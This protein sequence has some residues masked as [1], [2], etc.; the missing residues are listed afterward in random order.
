MARISVGRAL[1]S[2]L[3]AMSAVAVATGPAIAQ[4]V[5]PAEPGKAPVTRLLARAAGPAEPVA[6]IFSD[7]GRI[8]LST[9]AVGTNNAA[10]ADLEVE[11]PPGG[12]VRRAFV[13]AAST[14]FTGYEPQDGD[15]T[16]DG[17]P[18]TWTGSR[19][20]TNGISSVNV[21]SDVTSLVKP[22]LDAASP[23]RIA[24]R[25]AEGAA[26]TLIDGVILAVVFDD[27][28][29][30]RDRAVVLAYGA[31]QVT[32]DRIRLVRLPDVP[33]SDVKATLGV[34]ISFGFQPT[35][36]DSTIDVN[37]V[38][39]TSSAGGQDDGVGR[40]GALITVGGLN[41]LASNPADPF[42][43]GNQSSC[44]RCDDELYDLT[45]FV[46]A[47]DVSL[48]ELTTENPSADD[49]FMFAALDVEGATITWIPSGGSIDYVAVGDSTTTGFSVPTCEEDRVISPYGCTGDPPA[50]PYPERIAEADARF[51][52][53]ERKGIWGDTIADA[54]RAFENGSNDEGSWEPQLSTAQRATELVTVS[55]GANDMRFSDVQFWLGEC[56]GVK[57]K[58]FLG[59]TYDIDIIVKE[60]QCRDAANSRATEPA[61]A[62]GMNTMFDALDSADD[63]GATVVI[64]KYFNPY[65]HKKDIRFL[66]DR[67]C[68]LI[69]TIGDIIT[70]AINDQL[71]SRARDH[72]FT[73][74][75]FKAPFDG[76]GAGARDSY[77]F[78]SDCE[79]IGAAT[80]VDFDWGWP[81]KLDTDDSKA[82]VQKRFDPHP[83]AAGTEAQANAILGALS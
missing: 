14:G 59:R 6:P 56:V 37:G 68:T 21:W 38:R 62:S 50:P 34:G 30:V 31:Q 44:P 32:G 42:A 70:S 83:N 26:T 66:P 58:K 75:D 33:L 82:E 73:V 27:P 53:L 5:E 2:L 81:P 69:H 49:N 78:G 57:Q 76:H 74:V 11:K 79:T 67:S 71:E 54:V 51:S 16:L 46:T 12:I 20:M 43:R 35:G 18:I 72:D 10:G 63:N 25:V 64:T 77:V 80:S 41:D 39:L 7:S 60:D 15:I 23:G 13:A 8:S 45:P 28:T 47:A 24:I 61:L 52:V 9:D 19:T 3:V 40:N 22:K 1:G 36:Q 17:L 48:L 65:N 29:A 4:D 55:L